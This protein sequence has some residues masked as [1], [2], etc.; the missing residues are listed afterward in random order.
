MSVFHPLRTH[1]RAHSKSEGGPTTRRVTATLAFFASVCVSGISPALANAPKQAWF[2]HDSKSKRWC[3]VVTDADAKAASNNERF[4]GG[5]TEWLRYHGSTVDSVTVMNQSEDAYE[6][7]TYTFSPDLRVKQ[8]VRK[9]HYLDDPF[10]TVTFKANAH[11]RLV[12]TD[13]SKRTAKTWPHMHYFETWPLYAS[14]NSMPLS[15]L[16]RIKPIIGVKNSCLVGH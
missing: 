12:M 13:Q 4:D 8:V 6:E 10:L 1:A 15:H 16:I 3:S 9:G 7:D 2:Y 14:L 5:E 11:G